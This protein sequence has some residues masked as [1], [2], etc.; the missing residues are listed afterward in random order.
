MFSSTCEAQK[1]ILLDLSCV[2]VVCTIQLKL[3]TQ[4]SAQLTS[5]TSKTNNCIR[6][7][8]ILSIL[9][10]LSL[11]RLRTKVVPVLINSLPNPYATAPIQPQP[12][13][14]HQSLARETLIV[15]TVRVNASINCD[16]RAP[17]PLF[18]VFRFALPTRKALVELSHVLCMVVGKN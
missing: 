16:K 11:R 14:R 7:G 13:R 10:S 1:P 5:Y 17:F 3:H 4:F 18:P 6:S 2:S 15:L 9:H 12:E 8:F